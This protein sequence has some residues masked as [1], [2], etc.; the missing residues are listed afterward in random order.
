MNATSIKD[1]CLLLRVIFLKFSQ[2]LVQSNYKGYKLITI[3]KCLEP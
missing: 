1:F 3:A 2:M